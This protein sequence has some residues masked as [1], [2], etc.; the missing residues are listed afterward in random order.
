V[1][2]DTPLIGGNDEK[3]FSLRERVLGYVKGFSAQYEV[4][5]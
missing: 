1:K 4:V 2:S 3:D 5:R